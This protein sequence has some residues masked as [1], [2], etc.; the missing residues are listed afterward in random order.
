M[1]TVFDV[2]PPMEIVSIAVLP[3]TAAGTC[4]FTW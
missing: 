2:A 3:D 4:A 1:V